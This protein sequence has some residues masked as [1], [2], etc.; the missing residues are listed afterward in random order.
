METIGDSLGHDGLESRVVAKMTV[1]KLLSMMEPREAY[2]LWASF[3]Q[4]MTLDEVGQTFGLSGARIGQIRNEAIG[5]C[6]TV[7][8]L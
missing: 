8:K 7:L 4:G 5:F 2:I 3:I 1:H 6:R